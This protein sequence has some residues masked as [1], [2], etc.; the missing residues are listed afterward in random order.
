MGRIENVIIFQNTEKLCKENDILR[1]SVKQSTQNQRLILEND[2]LPEMNKNIYSTKANVVVSKKRTFEAASSY[3]D[4]KTVVHNFAS[5]SNPGGGVENGANA[6]EEC[7][8]RC[9]GLFFSLSTEEML[10]GFYIPHRRAKNPIHNDDIIYTPA[11]IVFKTDSSNPTLMSE[12]DWYKIDVITC[13]APN[14]RENPSNMFNT[15]D[16][17]HSA[18]VSDKELL[19]IHEKRLRR[20]LDVAVMNQEETVILGAFGCGAFQNSPE[21]V[22]MAAKNVV[23]EYLYAFKN[24]EFAV[25]CSTKD[26]TNYRTFDRILKT[27]IK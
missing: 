17:I 11:V 14:L 21:V 13:A 20:I 23:A 26:D 8:C 22:A 2:I 16:G 6:Q 4:T 27:L 18:K 9:S 24:I 15:G 5:A 25:Y 12:K 1:E 7:L 3:K 19:E 10:K